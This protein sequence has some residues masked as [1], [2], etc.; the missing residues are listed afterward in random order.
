MTLQLPEKIKTVKPKGKRRKEQDNNTVVCTHCR[1]TQTTR[2]TF[3]LK[4]DAREIT[5]RYKQTK[6]YKD[7][8]R[9]WQRVFLGASEFRVNLCALALWLALRIFGT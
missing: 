1:P 2:S 8:F 7:T 9:V 3:D 5:K 4:E 6:V